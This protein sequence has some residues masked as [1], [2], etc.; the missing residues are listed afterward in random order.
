MEL[1]GG[2]WGAKSSDSR[3]H[4]IRGLLSTRHI[5]RGFQKRSRLA[6]EFPSCLY[7]FLPAS[8]KSHGQIQ[9]MPLKMCFPLLEAAEI[10]S[11]GAN[12]L[13]RAQRT[14]RHQDWLAHNFGQTHQSPAKFSPRSLQSYQLRLNL[15]YMEL[16]PLEVLILWWF[17][18]NPI[19]CLVA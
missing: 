2:S 3:I 11:I 18:P 16:K 5:W 10:I 9:Q 8:F 17:A 1:P 14:P 4:F 19:V 15:T 13:G 12:Y 6:L 7:L